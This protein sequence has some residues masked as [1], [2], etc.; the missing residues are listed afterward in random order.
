MI[1]ISDVF[2]L[3]LARKL[4]RK[5]T[6]WAAMC[7]GAHATSGRY[8]KENVPELNFMEAMKRW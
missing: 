7:V 4:P 5:L 8:S 6:Y 3:W 1:K 2:Y